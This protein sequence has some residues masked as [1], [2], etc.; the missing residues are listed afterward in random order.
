[1]RFKHVDLIIASLSNVTAQ[2]YTPGEPWSNSTPSAT[3]SCGTTDLTSAFG[4]AVKTI[5]T[6]SAE[7]KRDLISQIADGQIQATAVPTNTASILISDNADIT[8]TLTRTFIITVREGATAT[9]VADW[10]GSSNKKPTSTLS[11]RLSIS[12]AIPSTSA[13]IYQT[14]TAVFLENSSCSSDGILKVTLKGGILTDGKAR[15]GSI[16]A[17]GQFQSD[18]PP[19]QAGG[20]YAAGWSITP[21]GNLALGDEDIFYQCSSG[22]FYNLYD[23]KIGEQCS[24]IYIQAVSLLSC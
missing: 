18:G 21:E 10:S 19:P 1:M 3:I 23:E 6:A 7:V 14:T 13:V 22:S 8:T 17:N 4:I 16:V 12:S 2:W 9:K 11:P 5:A 24:Q 15:I 20:I